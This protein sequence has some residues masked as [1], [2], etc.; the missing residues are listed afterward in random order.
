MSGEPVGKFRNRLQASRLESLMRMSRGIAHDYNNLLAAVQGNALVAKRSL[1]DDF[2]AL[3][4]FN[5]IE[6]CAARALELSRKLAIYAGSS[7]VAP[8]SVDLTAVIERALEELPGEGVSLAPV[9]TRLQTGLPL[10][11]GD[12]DLLRRLVRNLLTNSAEALMERQGH[13]TVSTCLFD[14]TGEFINPVH[15]DQPDPGRYVRLT[16][17]DTGRGMSRRVQKHMFE[18]FFT[19]KIRGQGLGLCV[20]L[21]AV[22]THK[23]I[24]TVDSHLHQGST[25][26][27]MLPVG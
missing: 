12:E 11:E 22:R 24:M 4:S 21:G 25:V 16:I 6:Q 17:A 8:L 3:E 2:P 18:P 19:T 27:V 7:P 23:G 5:Q 9:E 14:Y 20:A 1:P 13:I 15:P 10:I 26:I